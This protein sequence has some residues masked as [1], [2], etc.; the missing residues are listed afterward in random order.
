[1]PTE[2]PQIWTLT[3]TSGLTASA[4]VHNATGQ[5]YNGC[6]SAEATFFGFYPGVG[7]SAVDDLVVSV[8]FSDAGTYRSLQTSTGGAV[9][10]NLSTAVASGLRADHAAVLKPWPWFKLN[11]TAVAPD[12]GITVTVVM[13]D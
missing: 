6:R 1:M 7:T 9:T 13:Q 3:I 4:A 10:V 11:S 2:A 8:A 12:G 5:A